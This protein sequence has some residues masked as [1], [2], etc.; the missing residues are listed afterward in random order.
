[1]AGWHH[2]LGGRESEWTPGDGDGQGGLVC[3]DSWGR[4]ESDT[5]ERLNWMLTKLPPW[6]YSGFY[7]NWSHFGHA[8]FPIS[9]SVDVVFKFLWELDSVCVTN[10]FYYNS[11]E[12]L[13]YLSECPTLFDPMDSS[14]PGCLLHPWN[15]LGKSTGVGCHFL[16]QGIFLTQGSNQGLLHFRKIFYHLS[17]QRSPS[18]TQ[19]RPQ[20]RIIPP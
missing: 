17:Q 19:G 10:E 4:R 18:N 16:L 20:S 12:S 14:P 9:S 1:M 8:Y 3:C 7:V 2:W 5:T 6:Q 13:S 11:T 15:F